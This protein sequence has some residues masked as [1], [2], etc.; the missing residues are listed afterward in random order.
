MPR[1]TVRD[2][3]VTLGVRVPPAVADDIRTAADAAGVSVSDIVRQRF[4]TEAVKPLGRTPPDRRKRA[5]LASASRADPALLRLLAGAT[6]NLNQIAR[7]VNSGALV[8]KPMDSL[9][10][11][12]ALKEIQGELARIEVDHA[13]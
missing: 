1:P 6:N 10:V 2:K 3:L 4:V 13:D 11:L 7:A 8:G 12:V 9:A 5:R